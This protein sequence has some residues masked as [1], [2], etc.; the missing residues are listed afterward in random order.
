MKLDCAKVNALKEAYVD[1]RLDLEVRSA[2]EAHAL[3]CAACR[4]KLAVARDIKTMMGGVVKSVVGR[5][6]ISRAQVSRTQEVIAT[7]VAP[8]PFLALRRTVAVPA[9]MLL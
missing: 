2:I 1:G 6:Y 4:Q 7:R 8:A 5:P 9:F 3:Q